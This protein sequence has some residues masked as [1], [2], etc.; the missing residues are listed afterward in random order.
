MRIASLKWRAASSERFFAATN[1][2]QARAQPGEV[3]GHRTPKPAAA[4]CQENGAILQKV[5]L[6]HGVPPFGTEKAL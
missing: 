5:G 4:A 1:N 6:E 3:D 2:E